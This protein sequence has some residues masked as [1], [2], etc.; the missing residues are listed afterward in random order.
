M[1]F[2]AEGPIFNQI[3][4][5]VRDMEAMVAFYERL[6][7]TFQPM[8]APWKRHHG[9]FADENVVDGLDFDLDSSGFAPSWNVGWPEQSSGPVFGFQMPS[10]E[11][12]DCTYEDLLSVG[13]RGKQPPWDGFMCARYAEVRDPDGNAVGLRRGAS[14]DRESDLDLD[15][16]CVL[17][18]RNAHMH[19]VP[20]SCKPQTDLTAGPGRRAHIRAGKASAT[21][22]SRNA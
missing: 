2:M 6:G 5:V 11:S 4:L 22:E 18:H 7:V 17:N 16:P 13:Y 20:T 3:N 1:T 21:A 14:R 12:V 8:P 15:P 10:A 19:Q 9:T